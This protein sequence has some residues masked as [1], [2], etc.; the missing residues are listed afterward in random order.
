MLAPCNFIPVSNKNSSDKMQSQFVNAFGNPVKCFGSTCL[1]IDI[2]FDKMTDVF[3]L[4]AIEH[5]QPILGFDLLKYNNIVLDT[6]IC[7]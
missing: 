4:C 3:H 7:S 5:E 2:G 6:A 1:E